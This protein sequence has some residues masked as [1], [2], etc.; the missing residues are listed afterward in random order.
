MK[1]GWQPRRP[2]AEPLSRQLQRV[3]GSGRAA[4]SVTAC[5][6]PHSKLS[7]QANHDTRYRRAAARLGRA[8]TVQPLPPTCQWGAACLL[9]F[10][11]STRG[12]SRSSATLFCNASHLSL[13]S[14]E[15]WALT[16]NTCLLSVQPFRSPHSD[17][18]CLTHFIFTSPAPV[19]PLGLDLLFATSLE[20]RTLFHSWMSCHAPLGA[21]QQTCCTKH[22]REPTL[23][24]DCPQLQSRETQWKSGINNRQARRYCSGGQATHRDRAARG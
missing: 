16:E 13:Y 23:E 9:V 7:K 18:F 24:L 22:R 10:A 2:A 11:I 8:C 19:L 14:G 17:S 4:A 12:E 21:C 6:H 3:N 5:I 1:L 15:W 20:C